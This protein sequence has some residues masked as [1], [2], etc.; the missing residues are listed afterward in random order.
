M[1][2]PVNTGQT[3][4]FPDQLDTA[5]AEEIAWQFL[6][7]SRK[8][9]DLSASDRFYLAYNSDNHRIEQLNALTDKVHLWV[10][11]H[12]DLCC[13]SKLPDV[14]SAMFDLYL[15]V[16]GRQGEQ[17]RVV[18][19]LGQS[20]DSRIATLTGDSIFVT[21]EENRK[22]LH[23]LRALSDAVIV[24][25]GTVQADNPQLTTRA[26]PGDNP[27]RVVI[28]PLAS[29][30]PDYHLFN[31]G[32]SPTLLIHQSSADL[33][34]LPGNF[35]PLLNEAHKPPWHQVERCLVPDSDE[36]L[37]P[38]DIVSLLAS[39]GLRRLFVEGGGVTVS[40]FFNHDV[41][42]RLHIAIAPLLVGEGIQALQLPGADTM[43][44][45]HRPAYAIYRMGEDIL[46]DFDVGTVATG[47]DTAV[48]SS[49]GSTPDAVSVATPETPRQDI[50]ATGLQKIS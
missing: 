38:G 22:H 9:L 7:E 46:W 12:G 10:N 1:T 4:G 16:L 26:V 27:V 20:I 15:P 13:S 34:N 21:G 18:A 28:D 32:Q 45:A 2:T 23:C 43:K 29:L 37:L 36:A 11:L 35:G 19:H 14:I 49:S 50:F 40:Q 33:S 6:L 39:R 17:T 5:D 24:G 44:A 41:L 30:S 3:S 25:A 48:Y 8:L 42:D 31:D 47:N